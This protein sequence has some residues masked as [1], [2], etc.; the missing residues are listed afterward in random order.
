MRKEVV[1]ISDFCFLIWYFLFFQLLKFSHEQSLAVCEE[2]TARQ[3][4]F[5]EG[6]VGTIFFRYQEEIVD[7][8][9]PERSAS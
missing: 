1:D 6:M 4:F 8:G 2:N 5:K 7:W 3:I 9:R